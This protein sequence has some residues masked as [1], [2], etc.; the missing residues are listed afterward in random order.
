MTFTLPIQPVPKGRPI[1][2]AGH[3][4]TPRATRYF[5]SQL[6]LLARK[7]RP[8]KRL[9]GPLEVMLVFSLPRP[10][11]CKRAEPCVRPDIDNFCKAAIDALSEFWI[12]DGQIVYLVARKQYASKPSI[13]VS[14][15]EMESWRSVEVKK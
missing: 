7:H 9:S 8:T 4:R 14:I 10:K 13:T 6:R 11:R 15:N 3:A 5:E 2:G 1:F 12:D